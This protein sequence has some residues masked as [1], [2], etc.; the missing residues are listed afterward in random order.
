MN[1]AAISGAKVTIEVSLIM[2]SLPATRQVVRVLVIAHEGAQEM[3][4][5][6][7]SGIKV[8]TNGLSQ[9]VRGKVFILGGACC[10]T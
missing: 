1:S 3:E 2:A 7:K 10:D 9:N 5:Q 6:T 8:T 4:A